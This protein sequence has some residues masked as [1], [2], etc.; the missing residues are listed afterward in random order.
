MR[1]RTWRAAVRAR[2]MH[3][4]IDR[5]FSRLKASHCRTV[6][7]ASRST[8]T[9]ATRDGSGPSLGRGSSSGAQR[10]ARSSGSS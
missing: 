9:F 10:A 3:A 7:A 4:T 1:S 6:R 5:G 8:A 2:S